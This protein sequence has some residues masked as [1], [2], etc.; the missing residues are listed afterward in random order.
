MYLYDYKYNGKINSIK[1]IWL[2]LKDLT[3][4]HMIIKDLTIYPILK[5][6]F[7]DSYNYIK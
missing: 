3:I 5:E 7:T 1:N 2:I 4:S 6:I